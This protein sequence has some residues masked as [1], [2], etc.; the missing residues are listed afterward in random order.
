MRNARPP[1]LSQYTNFFFPNHAVNGRG[2]YNQFVP[3]LMLGAALSGS[4]GPPAYEPTWSTY[5]TYVFSAQYFFDVLDAHNVSQ[6][7]AVTGVVLPCEPGETLW[8]TFALSDDSET[9]TLAMGVSGDPSRT[10]TVV[11]TAPY[12]GLLAPATTSWREEGYALGHLNSCWELYETD[13]RA[14]FPSTGSAF[15]MRVDTV[16]PIAWATNWSNY[17][18]PSPCP[19]GP[20]STN[21]EVHNATQQNVSWRVFW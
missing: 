11:A 18:N 16:R 7:K 9:W 17:F 13:C 20:N 12:M 1:P 14:D 15:Q 10:S 4:S 6:P 21:A 5:S 2:V 19:G 3:Q 8:T